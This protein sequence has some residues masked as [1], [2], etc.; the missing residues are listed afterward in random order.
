VGAGG[1]DRGALL[2][3]PPTSESSGLTNEETNCLNWVPITTAT[4]SSTRLPRMMKFLKPDIAISFPLRRE[5]IMT[6][7]LDLSRAAA[8]VI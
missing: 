6:G 3:V 4:A 5:L 1:N 2:G 7:H 8:V